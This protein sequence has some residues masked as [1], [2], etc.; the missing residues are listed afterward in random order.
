[1]DVAMQPSAMPGGF[2]DEDPFGRFLQ[3][4]KKRAWLVA[5]ALVVGLFSG[6]AANHILP[7]L[8]TAQATI[9]VEAQ[10]ISSQFRLEQV[11]DL[12]GG[13]DTSQKLDTEIAILR[14]RNLAME[15]IRTLHLESNPDFVPLR[16]GHPWDLS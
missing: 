3:F 7:K 12:T 13:E 10:D 9:D 2:P 6:I 14:S 4:L 1:M 16:G 15:T 5:V 8:Y 11:Q